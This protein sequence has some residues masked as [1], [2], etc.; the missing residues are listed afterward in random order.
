MA[1]VPTQEPTRLTQGDTASWTRSIADYPAT[2][3]WTLTY[4]FTNPSGT[5]QVEVEAAQNGTGADYLA[6]IDATKAAEFTALGTYLWRAAVSLSGETVTVLRGRLELL[7]PYTGAT[8]RRLWL[9]RTIANLETA[10]ENRASDQTVSVAVEGR[11]QSKIS[12]QEAA[13][14]RDRYRAELAQVI[15]AEQRADGHRTSNAVRVR[16]WEA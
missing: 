13:D 15:A 4:Y 7:D 5:V 8:D 2:A 12:L 6:T 14:L 1:T 10:I 16:Y 3:G 11:S 9:E